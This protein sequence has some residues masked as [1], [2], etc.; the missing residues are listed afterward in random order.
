MAGQQEPW[1][2]CYPSSKQLASTKAI[3]HKQG[4]SKSIIQLNKAESS[5]K[6]KK[7]DMQTRVKAHTKQG[8]RVP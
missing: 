2:D 8:R 4:R 5:V 6:E 1:G 3:C 7:S